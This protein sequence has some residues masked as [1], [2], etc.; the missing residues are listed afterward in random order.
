MQQ[1]NATSLLLSNMV[2]INFLR[3]NFTQIAVSKA[4]SSCIVIVRDHGIHF[5]NC[6]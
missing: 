4:N 2:T 5:Y 1:N 3:Q 6:L